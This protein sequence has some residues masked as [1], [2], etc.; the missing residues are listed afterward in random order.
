MSRQ[1]HP[2]YDKHDDRLK[3][4]WTMDRSNSNV[5]EKLSKLKEAVSKGSASGLIDIYDDKTG[6]ARAKVTPLIIACFEGDYDTIQYLIDNGADPNQCESEHNL[7]AIHVLV[8]GPYKGQTI[9][10]S[11][12]AQLIRNLVKKGGD[13]NHIDKHQL[14]PIHKVAINDRPDCLDALIEANVDPNIVFMGER[15]VSI[16][17]RQNREKIL[18]K[19]LDYSKTKTDVRNDNGGTILHFAAAG[20][21]DTSECVELLIKAGLDV[22]S[23]DQRGNTPL[24]VACF[25]NK[26]RI[27][28]TL[29]SANGDLTIKNNE[30]KDAVAIC[31]ERD[32]EE[33]KAIIQ[34]K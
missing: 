25:F 1:N 15:A 23:K 31:D 13:V 34:Q 19:L 8:D 5:Q 14:A 12:R 6:E 24:M 3:A 11:Q 22:N 32:V 10:E 18:K 7:T 4:L 28:K 27:L 30:G 9:T 29:L 21:I 26:P 16:A 2:F 20:M 17:A 33:C